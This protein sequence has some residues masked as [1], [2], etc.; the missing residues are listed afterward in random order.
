[1]RNACAI[2]VGVWVDELDV[3]GIGAISFWAF[4]P[5]CHRVSG[6]SVTAKAN[7]GIAKDA[8]ARQ[9]IMAEF[10]VSNLSVVSDNVRG[11]TNRVASKPVHAKQVNDATRGQETKRVVQHSFCKLFLISWGKFPAACGVDFGDE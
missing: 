1:M 4:I 3:V 5:Q 7:D 11:D 6:P 9:A 2:R 8:G 10:D